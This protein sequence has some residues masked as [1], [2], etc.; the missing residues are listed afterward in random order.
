MMMAV[1]PGKPAC[2]I[3][4]YSDMHNDMRGTSSN[5]GHSNNNVTI[6]SSNR[7]TEPWTYSPRVLGEQP[8]PPAA[9]M[10]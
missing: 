5:N 2:V 4:G 10:K 6:G 8:P 1:G 9:R 7:L 3:K